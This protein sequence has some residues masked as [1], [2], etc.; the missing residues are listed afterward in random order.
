MNV[1]EVDIGGGV[2]VSEIGL[3]DVR[4]NKKLNA[5]K[6]VSGLSTLIF[7]DVE[8]RTLTITGKPCNLNLNK[9]HQSSLGMFDDTK[10]NALKAGYL[11]ILESRNNRDK[12]EYGNRKEYFTKKVKYKKDL[13]RRG[14]KE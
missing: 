11:Q 6:I 1:D 7:D 8:L 9:S 10:I 4:V 2:L 13:F 3:N 5:S 14:N 12:S